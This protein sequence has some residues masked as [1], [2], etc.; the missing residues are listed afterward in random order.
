VGSR[1]W[2]AAG[3]LIAFVAM[4][5]VA[6]VLV[7]ASVTPAAAVTSL[8]VSDAT[9]AF[10]GLPDYLQLQPLDQ[11]TTFYAQQNG[12]EVPIATFYAQ[13]RQDVGWTAIAQSAKDAAVDTEDPRFYTEGGIDVLGTLRAVLSTSSGGSVQGGSSITQQYVKNILVQRCDQNYTVDTTASQKVQDKQQA[14][15]EQCYED[16]SGVTIQRKLQEMR[17]AIGINKQYS[18]QDILL[19]YLNIVGFGGQIYGIQAAARYYFNVDASQLTLPE[20]ATLVAILNNPNYLRIDGGSIKP[21]DKSLDNTAASGYAAAKQRRDYVLQRMEVH[22]SITEAQYKAAVATPITPVITPLQSGCM[23]AD[24]YN[25]GFFCDYVQDLMLQDKTFGASADKRQEN[26]Q[27][28]GYNVYTTLNLNLQSQAQNAI[29]SYIPATMDSTAIGASNVSMEV[30]TGRVVTMVQNQQ[31]DNTDSPAPGTT[32]INYNTDYADGGSNGFQTGSSFKAFSL[33]AWLEAGHTIGETVDAPAS[34]HTFDEGDFATCGEGFGDTPWQVAND[35]PEEG[36]AMSVLAATENSVNTAFAEMGTQLNLCDISNAATAL[37]VHPANP[38]PVA[39]GGNP[40]EIVPPMILG[41]NYIAPLSMAQAYAGIA[42]DGV[43]CTPI[44]I[45]KITTATGSSVAVPKT[46]CT[47]AIPANVAASVTWALQHVLT[48]GTATT[49]NP[50]DGVPIMGKTGTTDSAVQNWLVTSTTKVAQA[51]WIGQTSGNESFY[52]LDFNGYAGNNVKFPIVKQI[53]TALD[54][55]YGGG[56]F[57]APDQSMIGG[58]GGGSSSNSNGNGNNNNDN[59]ND[60][61]NNSSPSP[62]PSPS[63]TTQGDTGDPGNTPPS[64]GDQGSPSGPAPSPSADGTTTNGADLTRIT[65][66]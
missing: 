60:N 58:G 64:T 44:A 3:S 22:G 13:N 54:Q 17:Y 31:F 48:D 37:G 20:A 63:D 15:F 43:S 1:L 14:A 53:D 28:G 57:P 29:S 59:G 8:A 10:N 49:A 6:A 12:Q 62:S 27:R 21:D 51:T 65:R 39:D 11:T 9:N 35:S 56:N 33:V 5:A 2:K 38:S 26:F 42:N 40:W 30:G 41:V 25:A 45:D 18:K 24:Q 61:G 36:G 66:G 34:G 4:S 7:V 16:A 47:Q 52:N 50:N 23:S 32:A 55:V 19:S 46:T